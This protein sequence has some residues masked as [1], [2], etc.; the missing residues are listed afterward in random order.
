MGTRLLILP[1]AILLGCSDGGTGSGPATAGAD[2]GADA[3]QDAACTG[4]DCS[5]DPP[6]M[7][8]GQACVDTRTHA[9]HCGACDNPCPSGIACRDGAC[10]C[11]PGECECEGVE[12]LCDDA[13]V[14]TQTN[15]DHCGGCADTCDGVCAGGRCTNDDC[16]GELCDGEC[17]D[18]TSDPDHCGRCSQTCPAPATCDDGACHCPEGED[19]C[20]ATCVVLST[21]GQHCGECDHRCDPTDTCDEGRCTPSVDPNE[22]NGHLGTLFWTAEL[23]NR[24]VYLNNPPIIDAPFGIVLVNAGAE[25]ALITVIDPGGDVEIAST[26]VIVFGA[27]DDFERRVYSE[28]VGA[29]GRIGDP[30]VGRLEEFPIPP[31]AMLQLALPRYQ[32]VSDANTFERRGWKIEADRPVGAVMFNPLCCDESRTSGASLLIPSEAAGTRYL[33]ATPPHSGRHPATLTVMAARDRINVVVTLKDARLWGGV[34]VP[35]PDDNG[36]IRTPIR[37]GQV[38]NLETMLRDAPPSPDLSGSIVEA[39]GPV[40]SLAGHA[41][42]SFG[43]DCDHVEEQLLPADVLGINHVVPVTDGVTWVQ[44]V[45]GEDAAVTLSASL[46]QLSDEDGG[47]CA[48][49]GEGPELTLPGGA[50]CRFPT[51]RPLTVAASTRLLVATYQGDN[52]SMH[53]HLPVARWR[54]RYLV[55]IPTVA[56]GAQL[57]IAAPDGAE[58][59]VDT[60]AVTFGPETL[61][62]NGALYRVAIVEVGTGPHELVGDLPFGASVYSAELKTGW[63]F[64]AGF[65]P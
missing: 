61:E 64:P 29:Q 32:L 6:R 19:L 34:L 54:H 45:A 53:Q 4:A 35:D 44:L 17:V 1:L 49:F 15:L 50:S 2:T 22:P 24:D 57:L 36:I 41:C 26:E 47:T 62:S 46:A 43:G 59:T 65:G 28:L 33:V 48:G 18:T 21:D 20:G 31:G 8:C 37:P 3:G 11:G 56:A 23:D 7:Q 55:P 42:A 14:D 60:D 38:L 27:R 40:V 12:V 9:A 51:E 58:V 30:V 25:E 16:E 39:D 10:L 63:S 5:C 13:C 52:L